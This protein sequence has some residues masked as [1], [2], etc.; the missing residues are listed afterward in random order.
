MGARILR[1]ILLDSIASSPPRQSKCAAHLSRKTSHSMRFREPRAGK[2]ESGR[3][4]DRDGNDA[5]HV[6]QRSV[7]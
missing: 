7:R 2:E 4:G 5:P 3:K 1:A 6:I